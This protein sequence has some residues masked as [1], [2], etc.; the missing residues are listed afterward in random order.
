MIDEP[1]GPDVLAAVTKWLREQL[2][3]QLPDTA[4]F[5]A[6]VAANALDLALREWRNAPADAA[7]E[8]ERLRRLLG[9][10]GGPRELNAELCDALLEGRLVLDTP[11]VR[12][13]LWTTTMAKL[14]IDQPRY[15]SYTDELARG[16]P[17]G[18]P[19]HDPKE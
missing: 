9:H 2:L 12:E 3:P 19:I 6:M 4:R 7:H 18:N 10:D 13:H 1:R 16:R 14:A 15:A 8:H 11:G 17:P 5:Q